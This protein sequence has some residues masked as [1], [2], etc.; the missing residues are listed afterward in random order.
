MNFR[1]LT[2]NFP[3]TNRRK[4]LVNQKKFYV[5]LAGVVFWILVI[6][7]IWPTAIPFGFFEFWKIE[8]DWEKLQSVPWFLMLF[9]PIWTLF[10]VLITNHR[11]KLTNQAIVLSFKHSLLTSLK[12][13]IFEEIA[14][15]WLLFFSAIVS[16]RILLGIADILPSLGFWITLSQH[17]VLGIIFILGVNVGLI[18]LTAYMFSFERWY[19]H[20]VGLLLAVAMVIFDILVFMQVFKAMY[21]SLINLVNWLTNQQ[22]QTWLYDYGWATGAAMVSVNWRFSKGHAYQGCLGLVN[23]WICGMLMFWFTF[24]FGLPVAMFVHALYDIV[25]DIIVYVDSVYELRQKNRQ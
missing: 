19:T 4:V 1:R 8:W 10:I 16:F 23:S 7:A 21:E 12:A 2:V 9:G 5:A 15:R 13:G 6:I 14:F 22:L 18:V 3:I 24:N 11:R 20:I 25:L 17:W